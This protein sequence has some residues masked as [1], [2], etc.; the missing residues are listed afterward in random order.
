[1]S[2]GTVLLLALGLA[3]PAARTERLLLR[4]EA[5]E[6]H[7]YGARGG[8]VA[9][10][11]SGDGGWIHL[12][13]TVAEVLAGQGY[14]VVGF[15]SKH[16]LSSFTRGG[17]TLSVADVPG[18]FAALVDYAAAGGAAPP[19]LVGVSEGAGLVVL[20]GGDPA[21]KARLL[22][23]MAL[24]LPRR[25]ELGWRFRDQVIYITKGV[26]NEPLFDSGDYVGK[27]APLPLLAIHSTHDEFVPVP[28]IQAIMARAAAPHELWLVEARDH[29]FS[30]T[31]A[32]LDRK[33]REGLAWMKAQ[34]R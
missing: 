12:G 7:L 2:A 1:V 28:E 17:T 3:T 26:P 29:S 19:L 13:P 27:V 9:V 21:L 4:G 20:A 33:V 10:V 23:V 32:E 15:D 22:G 34:H 31:T 5:Q 14:F 24:G 11:A 8:P 25:C 16:Y 18:D 6:L 30:D